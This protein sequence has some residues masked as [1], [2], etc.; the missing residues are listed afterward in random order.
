MDNFDARNIRYYCLFGTF[1]YYQQLHFKTFKGASIVFELI[2]SVFAFVGMIVGIAFLIYYGYKVTW[3]APIIIFII[4]LLFMFVG[5]FLEKLIGLLTMSLLGFI[6]WPI[7]A[8]L[9]FTTIP[10]WFIMKLIGRK[11]ET[12]L[13]IQII[14]FFV[15][16]GAL[17]PSMELENLRC[18]NK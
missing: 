6:V 5:V 3:W 8:Y 18:I 1:V 2:L 16:K 10:I 9:M 7:C 15:L 11:I 17:R 14:L 13:A 4:G 12:A